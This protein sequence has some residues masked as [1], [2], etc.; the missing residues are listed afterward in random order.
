VQQPDL[1]NVANPPSKSIVPVITGSGSI[2]NQNCDSQSD[3]G[4]DA[5]MLDD[6]LNAQAVDSEPIA[7]MAHSMGGAITRGWLT[8]AQRERS[9]GQSTPALDHVDTVITFQGAQQGSWAAGYGESLLHSK[10][11][12]KQFLGNVLAYIAG[13]FAHLHANRPA[14]PHLTPRSAWYRSINRQPVPTTINYFNFYSDMQV[15]PTLYFGPYVKE[16]RERTRSFGDLVMLPGDDNPAAIPSDG[17]AKFLPPTNG[18]RYEWALTSKHDLFVDYSDSGSLIGSGMIDLNEL[19]N[20]P[21]NHLNLGGHLSDPSV[22]VS[23]CQNPSNKMTI[24]A[25]FEHILADPAHACPRS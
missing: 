19:T 7:V 22:T 10:D 6:T 20:D 15:T 1:R 3:L 12:D 25:E 2:N 23:D 8:L 24:F 11:V 18:D 4:I 16:E 21:I 14:V 13:N 9:A 5:T 17:G